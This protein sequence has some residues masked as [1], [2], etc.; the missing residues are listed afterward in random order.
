MSTKTGNSTK[1][2]IPVTGMTC[3]SCVSHVEK[4]LNDV[5]GVESA[6]VNLATEKA[7]VEY[8]VTKAGVIDMVKAI[9]DSGY[10]CYQDNRF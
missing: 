4:A 7:T 6:N 2:V 5:K 9:S 1:V 8:D 3:A 10:G